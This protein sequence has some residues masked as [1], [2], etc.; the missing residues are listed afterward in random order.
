[1]YTFL[2]VSNAQ[3]HD[4]TRTRASLYSSTRHSDLCLVFI[5]SEG[6][7]IVWLHSVRAAI[8]Q[9]AEKEEEEEGKR[10]ATCDTKKS[11]LVL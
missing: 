9:R 8:A 6:G 3:I 1:M 10:E 2:P 11:N 7:K 4:T 5:R